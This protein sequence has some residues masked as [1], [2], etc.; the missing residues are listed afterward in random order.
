MRVSPLSEKVKD[1]VWMNKNEPL[2][3][4]QPMTQ[5]DHGLT[6]DIAGIKADPVDTILRIDL[7]HPL[8]PV[9]PNKPQSLPPGNL[10][11]RKPASLLSP[12]G[13]EELLPSSGSGYA[14]N[15]V[16]GNPTTVAQAAGDWAWTLQVDLQ[17]LVPIGRI[18]VVF[19]PHNFASEYNILLSLSGRRWQAVAHIANNDR[20]GAHQIRIA[21][22]LARYVRIQGVKPDGPN[23]AGRQMAIA[24][25][26][27]FAAGKSAH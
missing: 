14:S 4:S 3:F 8:V 6:I 27:V 15:A 12:N 7:A 23:Q 13:T 1:V 11:Y 25:L 26:Q 22:T 9:A 24:E 2:K 16:D 21:P 17:R 5:T 18:V 20:G 10:A 19:G